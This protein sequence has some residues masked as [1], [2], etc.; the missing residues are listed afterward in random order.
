[1]W[2]WIGR[3]I[4]MNQTPPDSPQFICATEPGIDIKIARSGLD[5]NRYPFHFTHCHENR[6]Q[7]ESKTRYWM[8]SGSETRWEE[9]WRKKNHTTS[10]NYIRR[11]TQNSN[12]KVCRFFSRIFDFMDFSLSAAWPTTTI[13]TAMSEKC[14]NNDPTRSIKRQWYFHWFDLLLLLISL[15]SNPS[16]GQWKWI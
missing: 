1:M 12:E 7:E 15:T 9:E 4:S 2:N 11:H 13:S 14:N 3:K 6:M 5:R 10:R 8:E 16:N